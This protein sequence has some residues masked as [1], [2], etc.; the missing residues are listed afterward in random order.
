M[1]AVVITIIGI[2]LIIQSIGQWNRDIKR[3]K[4]LENRLEQYYKERK[5]RLNDSLHSKDKGLIKRGSEWD[6]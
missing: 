1:I 4:E 5:K 6:M 3:I 2:T